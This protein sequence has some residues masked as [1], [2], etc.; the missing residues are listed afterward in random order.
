MNEH[1]CVP[2][3]LH[4]QKS[5]AGHF[6]PTGHSL[7]TSALSYRYHGKPPIVMHM[8]YWA[9]QILLPQTDL[10][11]YFLYVNIEE[12]HYQNPESILGNPD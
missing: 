1:R 4:W 8:A 7:S 12:I 2:I 11:F 3:K 6:W 9:L 10:F 5:M